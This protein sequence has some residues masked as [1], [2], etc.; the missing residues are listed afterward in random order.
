METLFN[1]NDYKT[2][3]GKIKLIIDCDPGV[4]DTACLTYALFDENIEVKL[5]TTIVGNITIDKATRNIL[6]ILDLYNKDIPV[7][8][9]AKSALK[10]VSPT[11]EFIHQKEGLGGYTPSAPNRKP[12]ELDAVDA[13]YRTI[14]A[15]DGDI[16]IVALGPQTN[17]ANL[18]TKY[19]EVKNK[20]PKIVFMG[21]SPYDNPN[22]KNHIS[23]NLSSDPDACKIVLESG[24]P[25]LMC[26]SHMGRYKAHLT[27]DFVYALGNYG[28]I[29][30]FLLT[31][32]TKYWEPNQTDKRVTTNDSCCLFALVYTKMFKIKRVNVKIDTEVHFGKTDIDFTDNGK[33]EFIDDL[34]REVFLTFLTSELEK[35]S[36]IKLNH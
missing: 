28:D 3:N 21:G 20:I 6:H 16:Y 26:P 33:V 34:D 7:A 31:M 29:G 18:L 15:G 9:G 8:V 19:P 24:V 35:L 32:Y 17:I 5:L 12:I 1:K 25:L 11:A 22:Y 10:R 4:D 36:H 23:F 27:E 14:M 13:M 2:I 30:K